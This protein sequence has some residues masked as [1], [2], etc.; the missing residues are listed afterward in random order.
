VG[1]TDADSGCLANMGVIEE[2]LLKMT[3]ESTYH[4]EMIS[5]EIMS[6]L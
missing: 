1:D 2:N 6:K 3:E 4:P 5:P